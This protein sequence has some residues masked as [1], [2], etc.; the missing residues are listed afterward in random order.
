MASTRTAPGSTP[1]SLREA[2]RRLTDSIAEAAIRANRKPADIIT[3]AVTKNATPDQIR[4]LVEMGHGDLGENRV[5]HLQQRV[6]QLVEFLS[7]KKTLAGAVPRQHELTPDKVRW[8]MIG[9]LQRNKVKAIVPIVQLIHS[10][11]SLRLAEELHAYGART[12]RVIDVL[13]Q[14]N[15]SGESSK[16]G[17]AP[18][19]VMHMAEQID[20]MI[21][22]RFRGLMTMAPYSDNP[23]D[24][25]LTFSRT[26]ELFHELQVARVGGGACTV[27]SMGMSGDYEVAISEGANVLRIGRALFGEAPEGADAE[28]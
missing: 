23:E 21:H 14:V 13:I 4:Q 26:A 22:L 25:R 16:S 9:H 1:A 27:L 11:D 3:V 17:I 8:H 18:P 12:D 6:P 24:A 28:G 5:Q 7:R 19:A 10:V 20:T 15:A 2:Y